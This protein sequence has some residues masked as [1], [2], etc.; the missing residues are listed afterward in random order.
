VSWRRDNREL[1]R[2]DALAFAE[3]ISRFAARYPLDSRDLNLVLLQ[4]FAAAIDRAFDRGLLHCLDPERA[5]VLDILR[6][7]SQVRLAFSSDARATD[8]L[9]VSNLGVVEQIA[10]SLIGQFRSTWSG[11]NWEV[12]VERRVLWCLACLLP[13]SEQSRFV[14][15]AQGNLGDCERWWQRVDQMV[16]LAFGMPR[17]AWMMWR[18][19]RR[20]RV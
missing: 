15:E 17:L 10:E 16:G 2:A 14:T 9:L 11:G 12:Q 5:G 18:D 4:E 7:R 1:R 6:A 19:G 20:G 3:E 13:V 8:P